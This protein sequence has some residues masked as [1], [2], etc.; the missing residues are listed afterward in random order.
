[1]GE[2]PGLEASAEGRG[3]ERRGGVV[4]REQEDGVMG[5]GVG[6]EDVAAGG[7]EEEAGRR[8]E[9][10]RGKNESEIGF[11]C[12]RDREEAYWAAWGMRGRGLAGQISKVQNF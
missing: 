10:G 1:M 4:V 3:R 5:G 7:G 11:G 2:A 12:R 9:H 8:T 6:D